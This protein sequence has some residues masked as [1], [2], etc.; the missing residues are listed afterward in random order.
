MKR[1][2]IISCF[3]LAAA[4]LLTAC[5]KN[6]SNQVESSDP[7]AIQ[8]ISPNGTTPDVPET[9]P[10][11]DEEIIVNVVD[12]YVIEYGENESYVIID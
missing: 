9:E 11:E 10:A 5:G 7:V 2:I 3:C 12:D 8:E 1:R 6:A 4:F